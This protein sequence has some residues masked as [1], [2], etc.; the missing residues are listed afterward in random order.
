MKYYK[1]Q[2]LNEVVFL[3]MKGFR[4]VR[5]KYLDDLSS[6]WSFEDSKELQALSKEFW[7]KAPMVSLNKWI[8]LRF[9]LKRELK[10]LQKEAKSPVTH[11]KPRSC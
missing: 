7:T 4:Y 5:A 9:E 6:V 1:T 10:T 3:R 11:L 2:S 8:M